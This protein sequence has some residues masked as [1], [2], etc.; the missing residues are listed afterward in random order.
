MADKLSISNQYRDE[1][2]L[3]V[4]H[5]SSLGLSHILAGREDIGSSK[6]FRFDTWAACPPRTDRV[7]PHKRDEALL[8]NL[9]HQF[10]LSPCS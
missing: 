10:M 5:L 3:P 4:L 6:G 1:L 9:S 7:F 2:V 8:D